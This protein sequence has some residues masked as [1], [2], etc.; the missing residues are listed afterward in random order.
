VNSERDN[1]VTRLQLVPD[2]TTTDVDDEVMVRIPADPRHLRIVR[3][4]AA[5]FASDAG[6]SI[7]DVDDVRMAADEV[8]ASVLEQAMAGPVIVTFQCRDRRLT[9]TAEATVHDAAM[10]P[11]RLDELRTAILGAVADDYTFAQATGRVR[12]TFTTAGTA[13]T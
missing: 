4:V 8:C 1:D 6:Y 2:G 11:A 7:D 3:M 12:A 13:T 5:T 9:M 10:V